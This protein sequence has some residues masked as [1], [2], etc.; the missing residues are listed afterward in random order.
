[1]VSRASRWMRIALLATLCIGCGFQSSPEGVSNPKGIDAEIPTAVS[2]TKEETPFRVTPVV[3][4]E[5][6]NNLGSEES[7]VETPEPGKPELPASGSTSPKS[8]A[9]KKTVTSTTNPIPTAE[10]MGAPDSESP[11]SE[12]PLEAHGQPEPPTPKGEKEF[13][14]PFA[15]RTDLFSPP[16]SSSS[17]SKNDDPQ[18]D[19]EAAIP[20]LDVTLKGFARVKDQR[21]LLLI[22]DT[23]TPLGEGEEKLGIRVVAINPPKVT[24]AREA[25]QWTLSLSSPLSNAAEGE[26]QRAKQ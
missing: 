23:L 19:Q 9:N 1:M 20:T 15:E 13:R 14:P 5:A 18:P 4:S 2:R 3:Y 7:Q 21:V 6:E 12:D 22:E 26:R 17:G 11:T 25:Q 16:R 8:I 24:L 10:T